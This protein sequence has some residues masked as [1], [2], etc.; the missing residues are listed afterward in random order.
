MARGYRS[1]KPARGFTA[2]ALNVLHPL[3]GRVTDLHQGA[4]D[5]R[6]LD[7][8]NVV[9]PVNDP[10]ASIVSIVVT[11]RDGA[12]ITVDDLTIT[13]AGKP[14]PTLVVSPDGGSYPTIIST[15]LWWETSGSTIADAGSVDYSIAVT[16]LTTAARR[17]TV[18][19]YQ[20]VTSTTG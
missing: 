11:R 12:P 19:L 7:L 3:P 13:P 2:V 9:G 1:P 16:V 17:L 14:A 6:Y 10:V 8:S 20:L 18:E 15:A 4:V 5:T